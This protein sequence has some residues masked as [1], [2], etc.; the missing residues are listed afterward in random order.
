MKF[1]KKVNI[2]GE[3]KTCNYRIGFL[4]L[5]VFCYAYNLQ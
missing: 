2:A 1:A 3:L 4:T 5:Q